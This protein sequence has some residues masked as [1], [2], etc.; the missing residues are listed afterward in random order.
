MARTTLRRAAVALAACATALTSTAPAH[1]AGAYSAFAFS[2]GNSEPKIYDFI[3]SATRTLD[4]TMY[5]LGDSTAVSGL[6]TAENRGVRVRVIL[7]GTKTS[8]NDSAY[9]T[10]SNAGVGVVWSSSPYVYT[11]RKTI[12]VD[13]TESL[14]LTGNLT[15]KSYPISRDYGVF[16]NDANDV[17]TIG[18]CPVRTSRQV[19]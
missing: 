4:M 19:R 16:D 11:H 1:A 5:E 6:V 12:T 15:A 18:L 8:V 7:D 13:G 9:S 2:L 17:A 14:V 3:N 10:L